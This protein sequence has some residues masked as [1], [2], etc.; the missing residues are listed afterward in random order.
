MEAPVIMR[1]MA[2]SVS[3]ASKAGV[4]IRKV[5]ASGKLGVVDKGVNDLQTQADRSAQHC[6]VSSLSKHFPGLCIIGEEDLDDG[7][8]PFSEVVEELDSDVLSKKCPAEL[9]SAALDDIVVWV[10]PLD[11]T[12]E[13]AQG[14]LEHVTVLI[15]V[16][17]KGR[18]VGGVVC[19]PFYMPGYRAVTESQYDR[20]PQVEETQLRLIWG[21]E[22]LGIF[23]TSSKPLSQGPVFEGDIG[24]NANLIVSTR[25]HS[26]PMVTA[27]IEACNP[28]KVYKA[29]GCGFKMLLLIEGTAH[30]Y[31]YANTGCKR[32]DTCAPEALIN[33]IGGRVTG[34]DG[35]AYSYNR[36]VCPVNTLG[37]VATPVSA[38]HSAYLK[39]IPTSLVNTLSSQ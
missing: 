7:D 36:D 24:S 4:I 39:R 23:G 26:K 3:V 6:I 27:A 28:T 15:G 20:R 14:F 22:G 1:L 12:S 29:G 38:W 33:C 10:D 5:L 35:K 11:G 25:S 37:V 19:Q 18:A 31:I 2:S 21:L 17:V 9:E 13:F 32:W 34:I 16:A 8:Q 30:G